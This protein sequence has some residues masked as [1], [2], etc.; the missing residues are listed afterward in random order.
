MQFAKYKDDG[1]LDKPSFMKEMKALIMRCSPD[2]TDN[3]R[4]KIMSILK[5]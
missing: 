3:Q 5:S 1:I 4:L 2:L